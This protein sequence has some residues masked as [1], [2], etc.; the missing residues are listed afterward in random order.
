MNELAPV[1]LFVFNRAE[2]TRKT[3]LALSEN[4]LAKETRLV[5]YSDGPRSLS[6]TDSIEN[7]REILFNFEGCFLELTVVEC[8]RNYGLCDNI[9]K[10]VTDT[11]KEFGRAIVLE[12]DIVTTPLFLNYMND[13]LQYYQGHSHVWQISAYSYSSLTDFSDN[14][15]LLPMSNCWGWATW[16]DRWEKFERDPIKLMSQFSKDDI[17]KFNLDGCYNYWHQVEAN[18]SGKI[19]TWAIFWYSTIFRNNGLTLYPNK[20]FVNNIGLDGSGEHCRNTE[21]DQLVAVLNIEYTKDASSY[22][23]EVNNEAFTT[24]KST[25]IKHSPTLVRRIKAKIKSLF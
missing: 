6:D 11:C 19:K 3:L 8:E 15:F 2:Q 21:S 20:S 25:L 12:D 24:L 17:Y 13:A 22:P 16:N 4:V 9:I 7:V 14:K 18:A 1:V 5:I 23:I 10:G